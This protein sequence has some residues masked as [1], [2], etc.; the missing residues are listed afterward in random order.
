MDVTSYVYQ[1]KLT[2]K[3]NDFIELVPINENLQKNSFSS[4]VATFSAYLAKA[5]TII[6][7]F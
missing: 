3:P 4:S 1:F 6:K 5:I 2:F 7:K